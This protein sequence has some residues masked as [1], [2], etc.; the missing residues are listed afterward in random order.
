MSKKETLYYSDNEYKRISDTL[1]RLKTAFYCNFFIVGG[2]A[3]R[4][5]FHDWAKNFGGETINDIDVV[6][7]PKENSPKEDWFDASIKKYFYV[8]YIC[9]Q[10]DGYY[11]ALIDKKTY[12][13]VDIFTRAREVKTQNIHIENEKYLTLSNEEIYL[14]V[15]RNIYE[16]LINDNVFDPKHLNFKEYLENIIDMDEVLRIWDKEKTII[17]FRKDEYVFDTFGEY[18]E[19]LEKIQTDKKEFIYKKTIPPG[20]KKYITNNEVVNGVS[21]EEEDIFQEAYRLKRKAQ[22]DMC[23]N[24]Q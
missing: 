21:I 23:E 11:M 9:S 7:L 2:I 16:T 1:K 22:E 19:V 20:K 24:K 13:A 17:R 8:T 3:N 6:L 18:K 12:L 4:S 5:L 15:L 14:S 10:Y